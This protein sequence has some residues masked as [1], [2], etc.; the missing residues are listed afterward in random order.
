MELELKHLSAYLPYGLKVSSDKSILEMV[1]DTEEG[2]YSNSWIPLKH[3]FDYKLKPLLEPLSNLTKPITRNGVT[4]V[5]ASKMITHGFHNS[6]WYE[7]D[8]FNYKYLYAH[9]LELLI[10]WKFDI[11]GLIEQGKAIECTNEYN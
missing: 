8:K 5:A 9:D 11:F 7:L 1:T 2:V 3:V 6:F 4:F 10:E